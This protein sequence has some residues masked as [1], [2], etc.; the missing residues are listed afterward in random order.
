VMGFMGEY[1]GRIYEE[2]IHRPL[3]IVAELH[4]VATGIGAAPRT[5]IAEPRTVS[6]ML[7]EQP[8]FDL[9]GTR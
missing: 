9:R 5:V 4:G 3:Y 1:I 7:G 6:S 8:V 2:A